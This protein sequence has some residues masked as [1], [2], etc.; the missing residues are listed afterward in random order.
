MEWYWIVLIIFGLLMILVTYSCCVVS[1][2]SNRRDEELEF[3][4]KLDVLLSNLEKSAVDTII[5]NV[6]EK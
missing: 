6:S 2:R 1:S 3:S 5:Q 4:H